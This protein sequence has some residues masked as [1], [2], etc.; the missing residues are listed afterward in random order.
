MLSNRSGT[1]SVE[2]CGS[3]EKQNFASSP[4]GHRMERDGSAFGPL[5]VPCTSLSNAV[6]L[7]PDVPKADLF[8][9]PRPLDDFSNFTISKDGD[10]RNVC[11]PS[12]SPKFS[13]IEIGQKRTNYPKKNLINLPL[14]YPFPYRL[15]SS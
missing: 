2:H 8:P 13:L 10:A 15:L 5:E 1:K 12:P 11:R 6:A 14:Y 4:T 3:K 7:R 9:A